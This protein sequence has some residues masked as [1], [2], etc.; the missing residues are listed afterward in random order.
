MH[1]FLAILKVFA[2]IAVLAILGGLFFGL[3]EFRKKFTPVDLETART[4]DQMIEENDMAGFEPGQHDFNRALELIAVNRMDEAREKLLLIQ[5]LYPNSSVGPEARR[6][7][8]EINLDRILNVENMEN[9]KVHKVKPG[10]GYLKMATE[11]QTTMDAIMFLNGL[12]DLG[13]L[14][15]GDEFIVMPLDF[16]LVIDVARKRIEL[17]HRDEEKKEHV[18]VKDYPIQKM[19]LG[20]LRPRV[21]QTKIN[22][23]LGELEG[24][25]YPPTHQKYRHA[26]KVLGF[27]IGNL[28]LQIRP[29]PA[30]DAEDP[31]QGFFLHPHDLEELSMLI[32]VGNEVELRYVQ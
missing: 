3:S 29:V 12:T 20:S 19:D 13:T 5:N 1:G 11:N 15:V 24:R 7:L 31:G 30:A 4:L 9:K 23:K 27:N 32:R 14:H 28:L 10:D 17:F 18:F 26:L 16:K 8:G 6:I 2:A 21:Y 22:R 25:I